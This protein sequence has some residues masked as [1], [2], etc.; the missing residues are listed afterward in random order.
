MDP[1]VGTSYPLTNLLITSLGHDLPSFELATGTL[2]LYRK[3]RLM[4]VCRMLC[5]LAGTALI[6]HNTKYVPIPSRRF[7]AEEL[8][9]G[10]LQL[11]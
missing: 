3:L 8:F 1:T 7:G 4:R 10:T 5:D 2:L 9:D 11:A 6:G